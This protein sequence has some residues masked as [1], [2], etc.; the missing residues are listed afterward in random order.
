MRHRSSFSRGS[1]AMAVASLSLAACT[2]LAVAGGS[3]SSVIR[4]VP[5][6]E[7]G[8]AP[9]QQAP[10]GSTLA[11][12]S[13]TGPPGA[14]GLA[15]ANGINEATGPQGTEGSRARKDR[16]A[17]APSASSRP[18]PPIGENDAPTS[19]NGISVVGFVRR[20]SLGAPHHV[21]RKRKPAGVRDVVELKEAIEGWTGS[22]LG[23]RSE[24]GGEQDQVSMSSRAT[25]H[26]QHSST[27]C[28]TRT[29]PAPKE[30]GPT[31]HDHPIR[32]GQE[33]S[34]RR[35]AGGYGLTVIVGVPGGSTSDLTPV[36][37][38]LVVG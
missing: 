26:S 2:G 27:S 36:G 31:G 23:Q 1:T 11:S 35:A 12:W 28:C 32:L 21:E 5:T 37:S 14:R 33:H 20:S 19:N 25:A 7:L 16:K 6:R 10:E 9:R 34:D 24:G 17:R 30:P 18:C 38:G 13:E 4:A 15:G 22:T 3:S 8:P 29:S